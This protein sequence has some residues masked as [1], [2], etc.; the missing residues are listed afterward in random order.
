MLLAIMDDWWLWGIDLNEVM[1]G[2]NGSRS[3]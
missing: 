3:K 1:Q 2:L